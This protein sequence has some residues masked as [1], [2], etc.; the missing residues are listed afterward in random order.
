MLILPRKQLL[1]GIFCFLLGSFVCWRGYGYS[2]GTLSNIGAGLFPFIL[3]VILMLCGLGV[4]LQALRGVDSSFTIAVRP[5]L[6][7]PGAI[8]VFALAISHVGVLPA[9]LLTTLVS[10]FAS[11]RSRILETLV[12][13][14][15][16]MALVYVVFIL[17]LRIPIEP[18]IWRL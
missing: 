11:G 12:L 9:V 13:G 6:I 5:Y 2:I 14:G 4:S 7:I 15:V 3:G 16:L 8:M 17:I 10:S 18:F 1:A